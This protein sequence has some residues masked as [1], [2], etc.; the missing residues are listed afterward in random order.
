MA[1]LGMPQFPCLYNADY[2]IL[3]FHLAIIEKHLSE[4]LVLSGA[5]YKFTIIN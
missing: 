4:C 5:Q 2:Y 1:D 3:G